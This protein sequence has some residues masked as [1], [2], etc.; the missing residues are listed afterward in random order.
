MNDATHAIIKA[1]EGATRTRGAMKRK[2]MAAALIYLKERVKRTGI[3]ELPEVDI[4]THQTK[5]RQEGPNAEVLTAVIKQVIEGKLVSELYRELMEMMI[6][7]YD[8]L[9]EK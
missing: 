8:C 7:P 5:R 1:A 6:H 2:L 3:T 9:Q 4:G